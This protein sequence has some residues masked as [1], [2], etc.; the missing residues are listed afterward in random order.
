MSL[1]PT[2]SAAPSASEPLRRLWSAGDPSTTSACI[3]AAR[4]GS[5][6]A[7]ERLFTQCRAY[8]L[9]VAELGLPHLLRP[10]VGASDLVQDTLLD[11]HQRF[12]TFQGASEKELLAWLRGMLKNKLA[13]VHRKFAQTQKRQA[14]A[15]ASLDGAGE[16]A[17]WTGLIGA[18]GDTPHRLLE[19]DEESQNLVRAMAGLDA[20]D[21]RLVTWRVWDRLGF[22]EIG[23]RL[24]I[25]EDAARK[26][27]ARTVEQLQAWLSSKPSDGGG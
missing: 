2:D 14:G 25:S 13:D 9:F 24:G 23:E 1:H 5:S 11:A 21:R 8:L 15:E 20:D 18:T 7:R 17:T 26:R 6:A 27:F 4:A 19:L 10:K 12:E 22:K 3:E 16:G